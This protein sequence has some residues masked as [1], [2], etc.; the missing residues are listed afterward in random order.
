MLKRF[1]MLCAALLILAPLGLR[2]QADLTDEI[3]LI[4]GEKFDEATDG[5]NDLLKEKQKNEDEIYYWL[6]LIDFQREAYSS[7]SEYFLKALDADKRSPYAL[8]GMARIAFLEDRLADANEYLTEALNRLKGK[9]PQAH[10]AVA[11]AFLMGGPSEIGEAKKILYVAREDFPDNPRSHILLADYYK[12]QGVPSLAIEEYEIAK[13]KA[14]DYVPAYASLAELKYEEGLETGAGAT[15]QEGLDNANK[16]IELNPNFAPA[17]RIRGELWLLAKEYQR[18]RDDLQKYVQLTDSDLGARIRYASFLFL[19]ENYQEAI[20][21]IASIEQD[22]LTNVML[23]L[24]SMSLN[25]LGNSELAKQTM[26]TYFDRVKKE[27]YILWQDYDT[28]GDI[29]R[30]MGDLETADEY[31]GKAITKNSARAKK[32]EELAESYRSAGRAL[33]K[34]IRALKKEMVSDTKMANDFIA[35]GNEAVRNEDAETAKAMF[36]KRDSLL[37][38]IEAAQAEIAEKQAAAMAEYE[39]EAHYRQLALDMADPVELT[40]HYRLGMAHY[41][42]ENYKIADEVFIQASE[43]KQDWETPYQY[44]MQ[45]AYY[46]EQADTS[47]NEWLAK[48]VAED[49]I[50]VWGEKDP[51]SLSKDAKQLV[52]VSYEVMANYNFNPTGEDGNYNCEDANPWIDKIYAIEPDYSRIQSLAD[53]CESVNSR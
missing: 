14:P 29:M 3:E 47:S 43:L 53:Y 39:L 7:A 4:R 36:A 40:H 31:Y 46:L 52:L 44:R 51:E 6:G 48:D 38:E 20:D 28:Y 27:E 11:E 16:A 23:R 1:W 15:L 30:T 12:A 37:A 26:D 41:N 49:V 34:E 42:A 9:D 22:T 18:A 8:A 21:E 13:K 45:C 17:Y 10:F 32:Y 33:D 2:A 50:E 19:S 35:K 5:L 25:K 24:K